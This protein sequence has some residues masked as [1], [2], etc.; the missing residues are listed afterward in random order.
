MSNQLLIYLMGGTIALLI[1]I[2]IAYV[3]INKALNKGDRKYVRELRKGTKEKSAF[4]SEILYQKLYMIYMKVPRNK[5]IFIETKKKTRNNKYR[6]RI[7]DKKTCIFNNNKSTIFINT[8][9]NFNYCS[10]TF[11]CIIT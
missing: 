9:Y 1:L 8:T 3:L 5:K 6:G 4:S 10:C 2:I 11:K 7:S